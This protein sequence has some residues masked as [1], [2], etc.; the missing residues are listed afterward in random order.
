MAR[1][2][3][4]GPCYTLIA[5]VSTLFIVSYP[6]I[7]FKTKSWFVWGKWWLAGYEVLT[8]PS[9]NMTMIRFGFGNSLSFRMNGLPDYLN[10]QSFSLLLRF[11]LHYCQV[12][13]ESVTLSRWPLDKQQDQQHIYVMKI[14]TRFLF[15]FWEFRIFRTVI[16]YCV[17]KC[18]INYIFLSQEVEV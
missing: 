18:S 1:L 15:L 13:S 12:V 9:I 11:L 7:Y 8:A 16:L 3:H 4:Q 17:E 5:A 14:S 6:R 10:R 2:T